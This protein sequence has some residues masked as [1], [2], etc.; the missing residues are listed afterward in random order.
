MIARELVDFVHRLGGA[1]IR[2]PPSLDPDQLELHR[3]SL[4]Q[5][6][7]PGDIAWVSDAT[8]RTAPERVR[9][10]R[11]SVL[12]CPTAALP[13]VGEHFITLATAHPKALFSH[14]LSEFFSETA[15]TQWPQGNVTVSN[16]ARIAATARLAPGV[17]IGPRVELADEVDIG[18]NT[19]LANTRVASNVKIGAN[20]TIGLDGFGY[21]R[22]DV[23]AWVRFPHTG[24]VQ[25]ESDVEIGSNTCI[26]RGSI[27]DTV[28][29]RGAKI[30]N[31]VHIAHNCTIGERSLIIANCMIGGSTVVGAD[32]WVAPST[33]VNNKLTIGERATV[34]T[35]AVVIRNVDPGATVVGN[36]AKPLDRGPKT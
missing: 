33:A 9:D 3:I 1:D 2:V 6:A 31:L 14:V 5:S 26:D 16:D 24:G 17:V 30:D 7:G 18:P 23:G 28:I 35:G 11:G 34:G 15:R 20:C 25:I 36:P 8:L 10:F 19:C 22:N 32:A 27:G 12:I 4:D 13:L 29:R 21:A